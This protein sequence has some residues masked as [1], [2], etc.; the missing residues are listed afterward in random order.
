MRDICNF[1]SQKPEHSNIE[2]YHFVYETGI[3]KISMP[4]VRRNYYINIAFKGNGVLILDDKEFNLSP[5]TLFFSFP[6][7]PFRLECDNDFT[8]LYISFN[9]EGA[10]ALLEGFNINK[11]NCVFNNL[12]NLSDFWMK[13][14]R[15]INNTNSMVLTESVLMYSLSYTLSQDNNSQ[16]DISRF[17]SVL[18]YI[19]SNFKNSDLSLIKISDMFFY[20]KKYLSTL[21]IKETGIKFTDYLNSLRIDEAKKLMKSKEL[22]VT[23]ISSKCGFSDSYYFSKVFKKY[24]GMPPTVFMNSC[25]TDV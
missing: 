4:I 17:E 8:F 7:T 25:K 10:A 11:E 20:N 12:E 1:I 6:D 24:M 9:G 21:F 2:C 14:I 23:E 16:K 3:N 22:S 5:G 19:Q 18:K 13:E 15:R